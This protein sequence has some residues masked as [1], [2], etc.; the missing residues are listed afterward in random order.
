VGRELPARHVLLSLRELP[1][2]SFALAED[3][4][5]DRV[6]EAVVARVLPVM[7]D[8]AVDFLGIADTQGLLDRLEEFAPATV[9][10]VVPKPISV[11]Q[12]A[13]VLRRLV[14]ERLSIRDLKGILEALAMVGHAEK[15][16]LNLAEFVRSQQRRAITHG[17]ARGG[18]EISVVLLDPAIEDTVRS[19]VTRTAAGSF[20]TLAPAA[21]RDI[22]TAIKKTIDPLGDAHPPLLTQPDIRR[23]V[24]K[25]IEVDLPE[26]RVVSYAELLPELAV[27]PLARVSLS[28]IPSGGRPPTQKDP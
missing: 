19:A 25:L 12:L 14:D 17:L 9:R 16:A 20:L 7:R 2:A 22:V 13:D 6:A 24:R 21:G 11:T 1:A 5:A 18:R 15:D 8:R 4:P 10:Q 23:F 3:V 26:V 27:K 28:A